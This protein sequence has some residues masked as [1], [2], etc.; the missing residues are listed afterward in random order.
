MLTIMTSTYNVLEACRKV[1]IKNIVLASSETL[2]GIPFDP[3]PPAS[4]PITEEHERRPESA[5]SLSK[6][7]GETMAEQY[8]RWDPELKIVSL[9]F[10]N[11][12]LPH[13]YAAFESW[14]KDPKARYW[15]CW[16]YIGTYAR[17]VLEVKLT[18]DPF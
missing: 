18:I 10:S 9:R 5:Y 16:G 11:V 15:N 7:M 12:M 6:L 8:T 4:L 1:G 2:I 13:E 17:I 3:H 14:Q